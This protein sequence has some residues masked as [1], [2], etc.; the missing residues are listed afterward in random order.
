MAVT[1]AILENIVLATTRQR[2]CPI[3]IEFFYEDAKS[4]RNDGRM[5]KFL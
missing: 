1:D 2:V 4:E 3:S 5:R